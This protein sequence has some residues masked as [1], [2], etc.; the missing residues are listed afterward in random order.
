LSFRISAS[1][2]APSAVVGSVAAALGVDQ[3][4]VFCKT[5]RVGGG[6]GG[7][8]LRP[9]LLAAA[10]AV[11]AFHLEEP[12][13]LQL[14][15]TE[16][17]QFCPGRAPFSATYEA[18]WERIDGEVRLTALKVEMATEGGYSQDYSVDVMET[19]MFV[20]DNGYLLPGDIEISGKCAKTNKG[21]FTATRGFGKPQAAAITECIFD[22]V[23]ADAGVDPTTF[24]TNHLYKRGDVALTG[25]EIGDDVLETCWSGVVKHQQD[26]SGDEGGF[27]LPSRDAGYAK[28]RDH[29]ESFNKAN[30][31]VKRGLSA[32]PAKGN[33]GFVNCDDVNRGLALMIAR[34]DGSVS[35]THSGVEMGQGLATRLIQV[36]SSAL[37]IEVGRI[38]VLETDTF[39]VPNTPPTTMVSTD[40]AGSAI[41][42][43][44]ERLLENLRPV[45]DELAAAGVDKP[46]WEQ[47]C[48]AA[49]DRGT[50]LTVT[51][52]VQYPRL[53][54]DWEKQTGD[55]AYFF[56]WGA[57]LSLVEL[58]VLTGS[59]RT[60]RTNIL[61][62][63]G[64]R[65]LNPALDVGQVEGGFIFGLG[66]YMQE[67][68]EYGLNPKTYELFTNNVAKY[69]LP[70][71]DDTPVEWDVKLLRY[72]AGE[73][74]GDGVYGTKGIGEANIGL[75]MSVYLAVKDAIRSVR[76][77]RD[78]DPRF[79][80]EFPATP[81]RI[82][83][84]V[85]A[86]P[87]SY[88]GPGQ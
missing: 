12:V 30:R 85:G 43:C 41:Q 50:E 55:I 58:D 65:S 70:T 57:A 26:G 10:A 86:D 17:M 8:Q 9:G 46:T 83:A 79:E 7:K 34:K 28:L 22:D 44:A 18:G 52:S 62:D 2:Q 37:D 21:S 31:W 24:R 3:N 42:Q 82:R 69:K 35:I 29:C 38:R 87:Y 14:S 13:K 33:M 74:G 80:L 25:M 77:E 19:A 56:V 60:L 76:K 75:G 27:E 48:A 11:P 40:L 47:L 88:P 36:A 59:W 51:G 39:A 84:A 6:F 81:D 67:E 64:Q 1:S 66:Y 15:R 72:D 5:E 4:A 71:H 32:V 78:L 45:R 20:L 23:A 68:L 54:Y 63:C 73:S 53:V 61:Q 49:Y 16:D